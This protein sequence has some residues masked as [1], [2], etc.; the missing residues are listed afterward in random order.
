MSLIYVALVGIA[1]GF[2]AG[3]IMKGHGFGWLVNLILGIVGSFIGNWLFGILGVRIGHGLIGTI[4][5]ATI[6]AVVLIVVANL[7]NGKK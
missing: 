6:G 2:L 7:I 3:Q 1:A 4:I 5:T